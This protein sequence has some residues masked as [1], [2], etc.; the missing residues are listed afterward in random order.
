MATDIITALTDATFDE[1]VAASTEP[2]LVDFWAEWCGPCKLVAPVLEQ[3]AREHEGALRVAKVDVDTNQQVARRFD[4]M[5]IP[6]LILF[7]DG[8]PQLRIVGAK[9]KG[10]LLEELKAFL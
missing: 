6:T 4:I 9:G 1:E 5:S 7:K 10:Q 8:A 2:L 3:I